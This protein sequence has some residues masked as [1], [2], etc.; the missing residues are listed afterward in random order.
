MHINVRELLAKKTDVRLDGQV[1]IG[2]LFRD[3]NDGVRSGTVHADLNAGCAGDIVEVKGVLTVPVEFTCSRCL[4]SYCQRLSIP[5]REMF[6]QNADRLEGD[7][8]ELHL[9]TSDK[10]DLTPY[11]EQSVHLGLPFV[12]LC[13]ETCK[14]LNPTT[15]I[16]RNID[17][18][19]QDEPPIDP[20]L[21]AL[22]DFFGKQN[23][24]DETR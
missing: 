15:G 23:S 6:T 13:S 9:A 2:H 11:I 18:T 3:R 1:D 10:V 8:D 24:N 7:N 22:A 16:N 21:A 5:F 14:G 17:P 20:R 19:D 4:C 12:P